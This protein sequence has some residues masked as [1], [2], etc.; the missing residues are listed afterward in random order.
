MGSKYCGSAARWQWLPNMMPWCI[1]MYST[2][3]SRISTLSGL[4]YTIWKLR[5]RTVHPMNQNLLTEKVN[6][7][8]IALCCHGYFDLLFT[9]YSFIFIGSCACHHKLPLILLLSVC[10]LWYQLV[11]G[12]L[13]FIIFD[14]WSAVLTCH[15]GDKGVFTQWV[16]GEFIEG[17]ETIYPAHAHPSTQ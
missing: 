6:K 16:L 7:T 3:C 12:W 2:I 9:C 11:I 14:L 4:G 17:S 8:V 1:L 5:K 10:H 15:T 13:S